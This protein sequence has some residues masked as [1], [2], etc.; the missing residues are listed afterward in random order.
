MFDHFD[1]VGGTA[2]ADIDEHGMTNH[3]DDDININ[4]FKYSSA[5]CVVHD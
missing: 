5:L 1:G 4:I 2:A 3:I